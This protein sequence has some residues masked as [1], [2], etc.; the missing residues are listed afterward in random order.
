MPG[1]AADATWGLDQ[2]RQ[3]P[4]VSST[5]RQQLDACAGHS[6][7]VVITPLGL[8]ALTT[9]NNRHTREW[10]REI[11]GDQDRNT[12]GGLRKWLEHG[13]WGSAAQDQT[14]TLLCHLLAVGT[15][16]S[17]QGPGLLLHK[18][19][20]TED[21]PCRAAMHVA[22]HVIDPL[23]MG[24]C[25]YCLTPNRTGGPDLRALTQVGFSL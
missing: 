13:L 16:A 17:C 25:S 20:N 5:S 12:Q 11:H 1:E 22:Y 21:L 7:P 14:P 19:K 15:G 23:Q 6:G 18:M 8:S 10:R 2:V 4:E 3:D 24:A 9:V